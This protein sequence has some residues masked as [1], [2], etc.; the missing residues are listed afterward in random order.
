MLADLAS[1]SLRL[2]GTEKSLSLLKGSGSTVW[3]LTARVKRVSPFSFLFFGR[4]T[5]AFFGPKFML[6]PLQIVRHLVNSF[7]SAIPQRV[8]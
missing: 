4:L 6:A 8:S 3:V 1:F 5:E 2:F 7:V